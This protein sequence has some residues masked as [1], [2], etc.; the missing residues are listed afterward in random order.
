MENSEEIVQKQWVAYNRRDIESFITFYSPDIKMFHLSGELILEGMEAFRNRYVERFN[1][2]ELHCE[3]ANRMVLG[4][5]VIDHERIEGVIPKAIYEVIVVY[6]ISDD[7]IT[8]LTVIP[9]E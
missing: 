1:N 4:N 2:P 5:V 6:Q 9:K 8:R 3:I 7:K